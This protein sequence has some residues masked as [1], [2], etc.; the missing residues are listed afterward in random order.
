MSNRGRTPAEWLAVI[1]E[2]RQ[3]GLSDKDWCQRNGIS[4]Q[5]FYN[6]VKRL[7]KKACEVPER[8][9][10]GAKTI[11]PEK[12]E[13]VRVDLVP[14]DLPDKPAEPPI[15]APHTEYLD[16]P[17]TTIELQLNGAVIRVAN[18]ADPLLLAKAIRM[19][20]GL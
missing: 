20:G 7:R 19:I 8:V 6:A 9:S 3:S 11:I 12:Q 2:A 10:S 5:T 17:H 13:V 15:E 16:N 14:D 1:T 18:G 4:V